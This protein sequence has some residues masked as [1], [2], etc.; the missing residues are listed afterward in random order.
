MPDVDEEVLSR[1]I[2]K[3]RRTKAQ[4][5]ADNAAVALKKSVKAE[6][7]KSRMEKRTQLI[8][9]IAALENEM[10]NDEQQGEREA[11]RPPAKKMVM[12]PQPPSKGKGTKTHLSERPQ[13]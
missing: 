4:I 2:P 8:A 12:V 10:H 5:T 1:P 6:E 13:Y 11:A 9:S 7:A 3:P